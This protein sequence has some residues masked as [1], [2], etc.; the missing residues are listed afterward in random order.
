[1]YGIASASVRVRV[2]RTELGIG[3]KSVAQSLVRETAVLHNDIATVDL[4]LAQGLPIP[5][6]RALGSEWKALVALELG[7]RRQ[8][9]DEERRNH[10]VSG[11][12]SLAF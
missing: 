12:L 11:G 3:V 1:H 5:V 6:L 7:R 9:T 4:S 2:T 8:G 10:R